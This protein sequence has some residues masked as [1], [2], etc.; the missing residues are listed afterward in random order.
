MWFIEEDVLQFFRMWYRYWDN[1]AM[2]KLLK[3]YNYDKDLDYIKPFLYYKDMLVTNWLIVVNKWDKNRIKDIEK[4]IENW[5]TWD[6]KWIL[7]T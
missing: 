2:N 4:R 6:Y 3:W 7:Y 1:N 5:Y